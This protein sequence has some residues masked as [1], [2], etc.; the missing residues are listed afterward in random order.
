MT[1]FDSD[2][3]A[4]ANT[5]KHGS[6]KLAH[7]GASSQTAKAHR[8]GLT[9]HHI[10]DEGASEV[11]HALLPLTGRDRR[12]AKAMLRHMSNTDRDG[13]EDDI[14]DLQAM[15]MLNLKAEL[16]LLDE[17]PDGLGRFLSSIISMHDGVTALHGGVITG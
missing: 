11:E 4:I 3:I 9:R 17:R 7:E 1:D 8:I 14:A 12:K 13:V 2:G 15:L 16:Q 6:A 10:T 5:Y